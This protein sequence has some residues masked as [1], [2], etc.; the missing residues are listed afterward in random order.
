MSIDLK[1]LL[2]SFI[3]ES[4]EN[5]AEM[6]EGLLK[7]DPVR[8]NLDSINQIFRAVHTLKGN[9]AIFQFSEI[10]ALAKD[11]ENL[12]DKLRK[13]SVPLEQQHIVFLLQSTDKLKNLLL[14]LKDGGTKK[15]TKSETISI[16]V[17]TEKID[18]LMNAVE[19]LVITESVLKEITKDLDSKLLRKFNENLD[20]LDQNSRRLQDVVLRMRMIPIAFAINRFPRMVQEISK[21]LGK[22]IELKTSGAQTEIDK[23]MVEKI[24]DP[25]MHLI[26]N[27]IDHGIETPS[28]R[29]KKGKTRTGTITLV[30]YQAGNNIVIDLTDDGG[31]LN[32]KRI[33]EVAIQKGIILKEKILKEDEYHQL[34]FE[35]GFSTADTVSDVSGRGVG[36][37]VVMQNIHDLGGKIEVISSKNQG[38]TFRLRLPLTLAI[39]DC[40]LIRVDDGLY[41]IPL[42]SI[43]EMRQIDMSQIT[44]NDDG[45]ENYVLREE[46]YPLIHL[47]RLFFS[48]F[49]K[50]ENIIKFL[51]KIKT[52]KNIFFL[53]CDELLFQQQLVIKNIDEN[54]YRVP[55]I[56]GAAVLGDG[57][58]AL[59]LDI[60]EIV[61]IFYSELQMMTSIPLFLDTPLAI[62]EKKSKTNKTEYLCFLVDDKT[63]G[64]GVQDIQEICVYKKPVFI[65]FSP[66]HIQ[67]VMNLRGAIVPVIELRF[68]FNAPHFKN[69]L[70]NIIIVV[71]LKEQGS[72]K[73]LGIIV[74]RVADTLWINSL[75][76]E[77]IDSNQYV[78]GVSDIKG[79]KITL[80]KTSE[81][82]MLI[83][84]KSEVA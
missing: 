15:T 14:A 62:T 31:G 10:G 17:A 81:L 78:E 16:R 39:M 64:I 41:A 50:K 8:V 73:L 11:L 26:R 83:K 34:I 13:Q 28:E 69:N 3:E 43:L 74:D 35:P 66:A 40:Q 37:D 72:Q 67:G 55:G 77:I 46:T 71:Q 29:E 65:P 44:K 80:L 45:T 68:L 38:T 27:A 60:K 1:Q 12:L 58:L 75:D 2:P 32:T 48:G 25:L 49:Q 42:S 30:T 33:Q 70:E 63:Y 47:D 51:I 54:Y 20:M 5:L 56:L 59:V 21:K 6:E 22:E 61:A 53:S 52:E 24:T 76:I 23:T 84:Q 18:N 9:S 4:L 36:L 57:A 79:R 82:A 19:S 7:L